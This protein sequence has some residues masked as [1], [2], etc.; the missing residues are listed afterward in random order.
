MDARR[1]LG[2][3]L[4]GALSAFAAVTA[5]TQAVEGIDHS[6]KPGNGFYAYANGS[7][8]KAAVLPADHA[9][10]GA[11]QTAVDGMDERMRE[12]IG[13]AAS[14]PEGSNAWKVAA[15]YRAFLDK[16]SRERIGL[17]SV[18]PL[19]DAIASAPD[20]RSLA[21][22]MGREQM[23]FTASFIDI[24]VDIDHGEDS[25]YAAVLTQSGLGMPDRDFYMDRAFLTQRRAYGSYVEAL[26]TDAGIAEP[27]QAARDV[28]AFETQLARASWPSERQV[29]ESWRHMGVVQLAR[30][31]PGFDWQAFLESA[32]VNI[33][34]QVVIAEPD[35][36]RALAAR[37]AQT[38][39]PV[40]KHW[41]AA[42]VMD[43]AAPFLTDHLI[44][45]WQQFHERAIGGQAAPT[46]DWRRAVRIVAGT[47]CPGEAMPA[48]E[49]FGSLRWAAG[50]LYLASYF[51]DSL[52]AESKAMIDRLRAAFRR[53]LASE[54][55]MSPTTREAAVAKLDAYTVKLG[56]PDE[57]ANLS[58]LALVPGDLVA[59]ARAAAAA[60][61][62]GELARLG[63]VA[64]P[65][66]WIEAPQTVDANNGPALDVE[67]PAGRFQPPV[68]DSQRDPAYN[69][70]A[71]GAFVGHEWTHGF[72]DTGRH[73]DA[74]NRRQDWWTAADDR[75]FTER[76]ARLAR[77]Y[78]S[79]APL[80]HLHVRGEQ[81]LGEDI[82]DLGG[83]SVALDAYHESL[84]GKPAPVVDGFTGDQRVFL[85]WAWM[86]R[87]KK[88]D[89]AL[90]RQ[91]VDDV[92]APF[93][94]RVDAV[95]RNL[96]VWYSSY[97]VSEGAALYLAPGD[98]VRLW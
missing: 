38:P 8:Q 70:G 73:I 7:W 89:A 11:M 85:G 75:A 54:P 74:R 13:R 86:W 79:F 84:G 45:R 34:A 93:V 71:L 43:R 77:Q 78:D 63:R 69:F 29:E 14:A 87:G 76:A 1:W 18:R 49:C 56:G 27:A 33:S 83:L 64:D 20:R 6:V 53:R 5:K 48:A 37:F 61:W 40:L 66:A 57:S 31:A 44:D 92:H 82:A 97:D 26:L 60:S 96:D 46:P 16:A 39:L 4:A 91:L 10:T 15:Y 65:H 94:V 41:M 3:V 21:S 58:S 22:L 68:F 67:F 9:E 28:L 51:P 17:S 72:D 35:A 36:A 12:L 47:T 32:G 42:H 55:W 50:D 88:S 59:D 19:L 52:R 81:T 62:A 95:V 80:P 30:F 24:Y 98:R 90:R 23:D 2:A 25:R